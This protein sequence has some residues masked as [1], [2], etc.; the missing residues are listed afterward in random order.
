M[1]MRRIEMAGA[2][3]LFR[4][5][6][7]A[8]CIILAGCG[9]LESPVMQ[10]AT[11]A[12]E[13]EVSEDARPVT[14]PTALPTNTP[15]PP[16][17]TPT[18]APTA[19]PTPM[20]SPTPEP[21]ALPVLSPIDRMV[22]VRNPEK[23]AILFNTFQETAGSGYACSN[24]HLVDSEKANLGPGLLN[25]RD[26]ALTRVEGQSAA[27][28]IYDSIIDPAAFL[29]EGFDAELM[30]KNWSEIYTDLEIFDIVAYVLTLEGESDINDPD[31]AEAEGEEAT[32][33]D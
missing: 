14:Q 2:N 1:I 23:G 20:P 16:T 22:S 27:E 8:L 15:L 31:P 11:V 4:Y 6:C 21:T 19:T 9:A 12:P 18:L 33:Q 30:P 7:F 26:R 5:T 10:Q 28:Y 17:E 32:E 29:V 24:C 3:V 13:D 25:I